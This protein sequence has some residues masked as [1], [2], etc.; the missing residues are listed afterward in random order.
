[1]EFKFDKEKIE[2]EAIKKHEKMHN[3][4]KTNRFMFEIEAKKMINDFINSIPAE[5]QPKLRE[6]QSKWDAAMK[7]A[8]K[9]N[10]LVVAENLLMDHFI[11]K[12]KPLFDPFLERT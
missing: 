2:K 8:G 11:N 4:Y 6:L 1:M 5:R 9:H 7:G 12:F 3:L 10:R